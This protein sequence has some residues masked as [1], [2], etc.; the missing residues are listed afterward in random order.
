VGIV[1]LFLFML[2]VVLLFKVFFGGSEKRVILRGNN[3]PQQGQQ[4]SQ[5]VTMAELQNAPMPSYMED[6]CDGFEFCATLQLRTPLRVL[7][8]HG[9][10]YPKNDGGQPQIAREPW[11]GIWIPKEKTW[12]EL[13]ITGIDDFPDS[14]M[15]SD[16]GMVRAEDYLPFLIAVREIVEL[17]DSIENRIEMLKK[18]LMVSEW[19]TYVEKHNGIGSIIQKIASEE[20]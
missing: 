6:I 8:R 4:E 5:S 13:G 19:K 12:E 11:E 1:S 7:L 18:R 9:E 17:N 15:A 16:I 2:M 20:L 10:F 3:N 14:T